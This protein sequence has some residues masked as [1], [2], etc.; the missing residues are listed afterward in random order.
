MR[1]IQDAVISKFSQNSVSRGGMDN[2]LKN[3]FRLN[4][5]AV[6]EYALERTILHQATSQAVLQPYPGNTG[7]MSDVSPNKREQI[8]K[9]VPESL[10]I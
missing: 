6:I 10:Q 2:S 1:N 3:R 5:P 9:S 4:L 7:E 8:G